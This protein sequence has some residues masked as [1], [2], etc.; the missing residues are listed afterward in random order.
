MKDHL[1]NTGGLLI[2]TYK[3]DAPPHLKWVVST[4]YGT[5]S[6]SINW[7]ATPRLP[8]WFFTVT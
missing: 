6:K 5:T 3:I 4:D 7:L 1:F 2:S 8:D